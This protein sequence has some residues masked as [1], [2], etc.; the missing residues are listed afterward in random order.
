MPYPKWL[1]AQLENFEQHG[2]SSHG[3]LVMTHT[4]GVLEALGAHLVQA[5]DT[6]VRL[7]LGQAAVTVKAVEVGGLDISGVSRALET[8]I[9]NYPD[10]TRTVFKMSFTLE[11]CNAVQKFRASGDPNFDNYLSVNPPTTGPNDLLYDFVHRLRGTRRAVFVAV[12]GNF[13][14]DQPRQ[15]G[16]M[17]DVVS[18]SAASGTSS[19]LFAFS[20]HAEVK[21]SGDWL[22]LGDPFGRSGVGQQ[23][24]GVILAGTSFASL[25]AAVA[26]LL[27]LSAAAHCAPEG[28]ASPLAHGVYM[29]EALADAK[30][31]FC[32]P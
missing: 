30:V 20:N 31:A 29:D 13:G 5:G 19:T 7:R 17:P 23:A 1:E 18:V 26:S 12:A 27:G 9:K 25:N 2:R 15:P 28:S 4:L 10:R 24:Q 6:Q 14:G 8:S 11:P 32:S 16:L 3:A 22:R 21:Q